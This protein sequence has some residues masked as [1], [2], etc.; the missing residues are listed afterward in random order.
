MSE[1]CAKAQESL[2]QL[3]NRM[4]KIHYQCSNCGK[5]FQTSPIVGVPEGM[6]FAG[7]RA[8]GDAFFCEDCVRTWKSRNGETF[9]IQ[10]KNPKGMFTKWWN[11]MVK[12]QC[13][14]ER[15]MQYR[16]LPN[17]ECV[18]ETE[19]LPEPYRPERNNEE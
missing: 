6:Y 10:M 7:C 5:R 3:R 13:K 17:G 19:E 15:I 1:I 2:E 11:R 12:E 18:E 4:T 9:D 16:V 14:G 8:V